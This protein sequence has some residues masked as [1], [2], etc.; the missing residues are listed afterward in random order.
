MAAKTKYAEMV[1]DEAQ[2]AE[3]EPDGDEDEDGTDLDPP[4]DE[5]ADD[6]EGEAEPASAEWQP[7]SSEAFIAGLE[8]EANRHAEALHALFGPEFE[9]FTECPLCHLLGVVQPGSPILDPDTERCR[10]CNGYGE[11]LTESQNNNNVTRQCPDCLGNGYVPKT[12][13]APPAS[14][15]NGATSV[16]PATGYTIPP[17]PTFDP[18]RNA[19]VDPQGNVLGVVSG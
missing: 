17:M 10:R 6:D 5:D 9:T 3:S 7:L 4:D 1:E 12:V 14:V 19:W 16:P 8:A 11:L 2:R 18:T 13:A 15:G